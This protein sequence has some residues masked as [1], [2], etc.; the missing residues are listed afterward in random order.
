MSDAGLDLPLAI[1]I[2]D[3]T[4]E[5]DDAIVREHIAVERI[6][7]RVVDVGCEDAFFEIVEDDDPHRPTESTKCALV[8]LGPHLRARVPHEEPDRFAGVAK[9]Q[10][11]ETRA[12]VLARLWMPHHGAVAVIDLAFL[13]R[14]RRDHDARL[15]RRRPAKRHDEAPHAGVPCGEAMVVDE[16]L[17]DG[18]GIAATPECL[19][20]QL[21]VRLARARA[22]RAT[23]VWDRSRVGGHLRLG[24]RFCRVGVGGHRRRNGRI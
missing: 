17:P 11:E 22:R 15:R 23:R 21:A 19:G 3:A 13:T 14:R 7:R 24:G 9:R 2:A 10:D 4:R 6:E 5:C 8:E 12:P 1:G 16:V 18:H 20:D